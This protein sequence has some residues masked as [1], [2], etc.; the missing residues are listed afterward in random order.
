MLPD[1]AT[2]AAIDL[3]HRGRHD[4][5][6]P[7]RIDFDT[8]LAK[9]I[10][11]LLH[12][13]R[14]GIDGAFAGQTRVAEV[15]AELGDA[16]LARQLNLEHPL[17][18]V[19]LA[20]EVARELALRRV[21]QSLRDLHNLTLSSEY[22][23]AC[24]PM[25]VE[26][27]NASEAEA[28]LR[29]LLGLP[30]AAPAPHGGEDQFQEWHGEDRR[31]DLARELATAPSRTRALARQAAERVSER[32]IS[33]RADRSLADARQLA[34][35]AQAPHEIGHTWQVDGRLEA[36]D[37]TGMTLWVVALGGIERQSVQAWHHGRVL[38][39]HL[40]PGQTLVVPTALL[41]DEILIEAIQ[42]W[43][44]TR[45]EY[46]R[47]HWGVRERRLPQLTVE[48]N[49][50]LP[51]GGDEEELRGRELDSLMELDRTP[52]WFAADPR[53]RTHHRFGQ[54]GSAM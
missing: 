4:L 41:C 12:L 19:Q 43:Y 3:E 18:N 35:R 7:P 26:H 23:F 46:R 1:G 29:R 48:V 33:W 22:P 44:M 36:P 21:V 30:A 8:R 14:H 11:Q 39:G 9:A 6:S 45:F 49:W 42:R 52:P 50:V 5:L 20:F 2:P 25:Y 32:L 40:G 53:L 47:G 24:G 15:E 54:D 37:G 13:C 10:Q 51:A 16:P 17:R 38:P 28:L 31:A 34:F 27:M